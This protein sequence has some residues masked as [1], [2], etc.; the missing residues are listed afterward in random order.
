MFNIFQTVVSFALA[1]NYQ[2]S[3]NGMYIVFILF[4][5]IIDLRFIII[6]LITY[7]TRKNA[8]KIYLG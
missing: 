1:L 4:L 2:P 3:A 5:F 6:K 7:N 8:I